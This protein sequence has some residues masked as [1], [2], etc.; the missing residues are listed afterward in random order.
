LTL[1]GCTVRENKATGNGGGIINQFDGAL[2][3]DRT[4]VAQNEADA[5]GAGG[6][7]GGGIF[8]QSGPVELHNGSSVTGNSPDN[9]DGRGASPTRR[10]P[11]R[12]DRAVPAE[13]TADRIAI[14]RSR[15][16]GP[17]GSR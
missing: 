14:G 4:T 3:L 7:T 2:N 6:G 10:G 8:N 11:V 5:D 15:A 13:P 9:Y 12:R 16:V 1:I 17:S